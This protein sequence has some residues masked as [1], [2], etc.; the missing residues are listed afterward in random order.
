MTPERPSVSSQ[1][2]EP[3]TDFNARPLPLIRLNLTALTLYRIHRSK[4]PALFFNRRSTSSFVYRFDAA[5]DEFG[6]LYASPSFAACMAETVIRNSFEHGHLPL[7]VDQH[8]ID[9]HSI[10]TI[11]LS[12]A[13]ELV[14]ADLTQPLFP[15]GGNAQILATG[16]YRLPN[17]WSSAIHAHPERVDGIYFRSRYA[18]EPCVALF[19]RANLLACASPVALTRF[20]GLGAFLDQYNI[21]LV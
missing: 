18:N 15:L 11:G 6:V 12:T 14:L 1:C 4:F 7:L 8:E 9:T 10:S 13:R 20:P 5:E 16:D 17:L 3:P 21:Y 19:D 2:P